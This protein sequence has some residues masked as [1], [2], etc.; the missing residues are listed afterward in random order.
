MPGLNFRKI[1]SCSSESATN[2]AENLLKTK[3]WTCKEGGEAQHVVLELDGPAQIKSLNIGNEHSAFIEVQVGN[4]CDGA[5]TNPDKFKTLLLATK[6]MSEKDSRNSEKTNQV[7]CFN[8]DD[9]DRDAASGEWDL[10]KVICTQVFNKHVQYGLGFITMYGKPRV[11]KD[12]V[13]TTSEPATS[14]TAATS[15]KPIM[16][17]KFKMRE[18]SPEDDQPKGDGLMA[19]WKQQ[20]DKPGEMLVPP[21]KLLP[22]DRNRTSLVYD[23]DD[24]DDKKFEK[25]AK[26]IRAEKTKKEEKVKDTPPP[27]PKIKNFSEFLSVKDSPS[28]SSKASSSKTPEKKKRDEESSGKRK[29]DSSPKSSEKRKS[30]STTSEKRKR[31]RSPSKKREPSPKRNS[32]PERKRPRE[33]SPQ[34]SPKPSSSREPKKPATRRPFKELLNGV[35]FVISGIQNPER[36]DL[37]SKALALGAKYSADWTDSCTHLICAFKNTPKY[38]EVQGKGQF[39][40]F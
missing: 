23:K 12:Q 9:F 6:F 17:G 1:H 20:R 16:F 26:K 39:K 13:A 31:E 30:S 5:L 4:S 14:T 37:R 15:K 33:K 8:R 2:P 21:P 10:V 36:A 24:D 7:R 27:K 18:E 28:S 32:T 38:R 19:R 22:A 3:K 29:R 34:P 25:S 40:V 11:A 35:V